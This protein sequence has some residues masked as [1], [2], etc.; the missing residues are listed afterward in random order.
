[1]KARHV[2]LLLAILALPLVT[3]VLY[4]T[5]CGEESFMSRPASSGICNWEKGDGRCDSDGDCCPGR[6]C[7]ALGFCE[8]C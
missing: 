3:S 5:C 7:S 6:K 2:Y 8:S 4:S 1:M